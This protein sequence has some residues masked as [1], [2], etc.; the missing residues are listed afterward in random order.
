MILWVVFLSCVCA[1]VILVLTFY[2]LPYGFNAFTFHPILF[3]VPCSLFSALRR[4]QRR[5][6]LAV[7]LRRRGVHPA[8]AQLRHGRRGVLPRAAV[9]GAARARQPEYVLPLAVPRRQRGSQRA[10]RAEQ[11][12]VPVQQAVPK[13][14]GFVHEPPSGQGDFAQAV[15]GRE[16]YSSQLVLIRSIRC[17]TLTGN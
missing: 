3:P 14:G 6:C 12:L 1:V 5:P 16:R 15:L 8:C 4:Q 10:P 11:A 9:P 13:T 7:R 17:L 2:V